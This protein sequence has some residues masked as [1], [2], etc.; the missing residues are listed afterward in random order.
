[1]P[2]RQYGTGTLG[3]VNRDIN[4]LGSTIKVMLVTPSYTYNA[5]HDFVND[6]AANELSGTGYA[7]GFSGAGR[8]TLASKS[9]ALNGGSTR[10]EFDAADVTWTAL[11]GAAGTIGGAILY[12]EGT[13]DADSR[14]IAYL[15]PDDLVPNGSDVTLAWNSG[16]LLYWSVPSGVYP[17]GWLQIINR[18]ID[19]VGGTI[20]V[21][22]AATSYTFSAAHVDMADVT[23]LTTGT[24]YAGGFSGSGRKTLASKS[25]TND[26]TNDRVEF[27]FADPVWTGIDAGTIGGILV[28]ANGTADSDSV[29]IAFDN[30]TDRATNG[31]DMTYAVNAEGLLQWSYAS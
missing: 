19:L 6:V 3:I 1:M 7:A 9:L 25:I 29:L 13:S 15:D 27:D 31:G 14:L 18:T 26:T 12:Q 21:A 4:L 8:K 23:E 30:T 2:S 17:T 11:A 28:Y 20:K 22:L 16:G 5:D 24:G 10:V